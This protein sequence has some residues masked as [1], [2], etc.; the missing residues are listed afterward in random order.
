MLVLK[1]RVNE[2]VVIGGTIRVCLLESFEHG[3]R[4]GVDA[5]RS[6]SVHREEIQKHKPTEFVVVVSDDLIDSLVEAVS[7]APRAELKSRIATVLGRQS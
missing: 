3:A 5:P 2:C 6:V 1:R 7:S 4:L